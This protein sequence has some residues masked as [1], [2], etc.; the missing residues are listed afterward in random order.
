L[1]LDT[2]SL[3]V[4]RYI[5]GHSNIVKADPFGPA[6]SQRR[7][8][9]LAVDLRRAPLALSGVLTTSGRSQRL[10]SQAALCLAG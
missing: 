10:V 1:G 8:P 5:Q 4:A 6:L 2:H 9:F 7:D 3:L